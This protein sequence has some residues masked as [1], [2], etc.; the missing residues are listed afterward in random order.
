MVRLLTRERSVVVCRR[1]ILAFGDVLAV[2]RSL[3]PSVH[4]DTEI[5]STKNLTL[6]QVN[7]PLLLMLIDSAVLE[8]EEDCAYRRKRAKGSEYLDGVAFIVEGTSTAVI[9]DPEEVYRPE[10]GKHSQGACVVGTI[11]N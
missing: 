1:G 8:V 7:L 4:D 11:I 3:Q 5:S 6:D 2:R 10:T 9:K